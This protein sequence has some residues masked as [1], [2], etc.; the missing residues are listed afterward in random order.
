MDVA[1]LTSEAGNLPQLRKQAQELEGLFLNTLMKQMFV[2]SAAQEPG[3]GGGHAEETWRSM[4]AE[5]MAAAVAEAGGI[6]LAEQILSD[7]LMVQE[8]A[9]ATQPSFIGAYR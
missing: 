8:R 6:G 9:Q 7:L 5:Q 3:F 1:A 2:S 4:Q